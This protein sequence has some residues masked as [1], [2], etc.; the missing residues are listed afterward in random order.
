MIKDQIQE[1]RIINELAGRYVNIN[2]SVFGFTDYVE[3]HIRNVYDFLKAHGMEV[4][5]VERTGKLEVNIT[6]N[7]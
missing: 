6:I 4:I 7:I 5:V 2:Y 1:Y 3:E